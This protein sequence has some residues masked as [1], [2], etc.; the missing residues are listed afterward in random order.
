MDGPIC[1]W[2]ERKW[3]YTK[4]D[5]TGSTDFMILSN[6]EL[7]V[8]T[9][10]KQFFVNLIFAFVFGRV[11]HDINSLSLVSIQFNYKIFICSRLQCPYDR[12]EWLAKHIPHS[13]W[14][15]TQYQT[16]RLIAF[17]PFV[18]IFSRT[19]REYL[20]WIAVT[21]LRDGV[22]VQ[23][24]SVKCEIKTGCRLIQ[25]TGECCPEYQ[26]GK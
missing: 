11:E 13:M 6:Y 23:K 4:N 20:L 3:K 25:K 10:C 18:W 5:S 15:A 7:D 9:D 12:G 26:C 16:V 2:I 21:C 14:I 8:L 19:N 1:K 24:S 17:F 22:E